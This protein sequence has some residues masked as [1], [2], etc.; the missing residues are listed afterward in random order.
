MPTGVRRRS[1]RRTGRHRRY[2]H[3]RCAA[4]CRA[5]RLAS[6]AVR[7][8]IAR[9]TPPSSTSA[10][11]VGAAHAAAAVEE[12]VARPARARGAGDDRGCRG[13]ACSW[14]MRSLLAVLRRGAE[15]GR[16]RRRRASW[17]P[18][19]RRSARSGTDPVRAARCQAPCWDRPC[20]ADETFRSG[21]GSARRRAAWRGR[22]R[23][24]SRRV[25]WLTRSIT[26]RLQ[27]PD[28]STSYPT[29]KSAQIKLCNV[30]PIV[31][32]S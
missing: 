9:A 23:C 28:P 22:A 10:R 1:G 15:H 18:R 4:G 19:P 24:R 6:A 2:R 5:A 11:H 29:G 31:A 12:A 17:P 32:A 16:A 13:R 26:L 27:E 14:S 7:R 25:S 3:G 20:G 30:L 21:P 8:S